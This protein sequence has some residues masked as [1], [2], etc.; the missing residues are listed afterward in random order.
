MTESIENYSRSS[1]SAREMLFFCRRSS[2]SYEYGLIKRLR[3]AGWKVSV[4]SSMGQAKEI[5]S[6]SQILVAIACFCNEGEGDNSDI[7]RTIKRYVGLKWVA[8]LDFSISHESE[9]RSIIY[10]WCYDYITLPIDIERLLFAVGHA[11]GIA[12]LADYQQR[13]QERTHGSQGMMGCSPV[14]LELF[15]KIEKVARSDETVLIQGETGTG[16]EMIARAIHKSSSRADKPFIAVNCAAL[17]N[18]LIFSELFG[19]VAGAF[20]DA[21]EDKTGLIE[22]ADG[23][24]IFF[25]EIS[26]LPVESQ[27]ALLRFLQEKSITRI[28]EATVLPV[29]VRVMVATN[30]DLWQATKKNEFREDLYYRLDVLKLVSP[31]LRL[32]GNDASIIAR[33]I[34]QD[35][36]KSKGLERKIFS[37]EAIRC[38][39]SHYWPGNVRELIHRVR[40]AA[41]LSVNKIIDADDLELNKVT[42][43]YSKCLKEIKDEAEAKAIR[44][45]LKTSGSITSSAKELGISRVTLYRLIGKYSIDATRC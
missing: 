31:P 13:V 29:D 24:I 22:S 11:Y 43:M 8:L 36:I 37:S 45:S 9:L 16:K 39:Q 28:G 32:R 5:L 3:E 26:D 42:Q 27:T 38:I 15:E 7:I 6:S 14:M 20:T 1:D 34:L 10:S 40:R 33:S 23:G 17:P 44:F 41:I 2:G 25:D 21:K 19:Y 4:A 18:E 30:R 35:F 12:R